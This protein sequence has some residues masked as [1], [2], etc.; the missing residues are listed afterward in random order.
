MGNDDFDG[1]Q[2][3]LR[4]GRLIGT[5]RNSGAVTV[6]FTAVQFAKVVKIIEEYKT[7]V[8]RRAGLP[9]STP[10]E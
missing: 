1:I 7:V 8:Y 4:F 6:V 2:E 3:A 10:A 9:V 5:D